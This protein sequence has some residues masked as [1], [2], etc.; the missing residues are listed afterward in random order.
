M[1]RKEEMEGKY[2]SL[3]GIDVVNPVILKEKFFNGKVAPTVA[4]GRIYEMFR[5]DDFPAF[6]LGGRWHCPTYKFLEWW[7]R[8][9]EEGRNIKL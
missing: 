7:D 4:P 5:R 2:P 1:K 9:A 8:L 6:K 3:N